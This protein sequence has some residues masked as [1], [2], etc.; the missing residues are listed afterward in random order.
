M[1]YYAFN[2]FCRYSGQKSKDLQKHFSRS[3]DIELDLNFLKYIYQQGD[4]I[5]TMKHR[6]SASTVKIKIISYL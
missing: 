2:L 4:Y 1:R 5:A 3:N 6:F